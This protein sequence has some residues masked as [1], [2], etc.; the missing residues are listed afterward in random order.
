[1]SSSVVLRECPLKKTAS[2]LTNPTDSQESERERI[3]VNFPVIYRFRIK[4]APHS[5][6]LAWKIPWMEEPGGLQSMGSL[7]VGND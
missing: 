4:M 2:V 3:I 7:R 5:G 6:T 1:M